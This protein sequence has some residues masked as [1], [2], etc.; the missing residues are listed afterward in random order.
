MFLIFVLVLSL[1][2]LTPTF[3]SYAQTT[4]HIPHFVTEAL[5]LSCKQSF[6]FGR[7][8]V[9]ISSHKLSIQ[10]EFICSFPQFHD[11]FLSYTFL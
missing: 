1:L 6:I 4:C 7:L 8:W 11:C 10:A 2:I 3:F 9:P 5:W